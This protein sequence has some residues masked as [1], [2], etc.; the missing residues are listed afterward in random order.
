MVGWGVNEEMRL[1]RA[2]NIIFPALQNMFVGKK[3]ILGVEVRHPVEI[4]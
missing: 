2:S 1:G 3:D 4:M